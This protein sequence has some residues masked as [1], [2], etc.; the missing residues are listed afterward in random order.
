MSFTFANPKLH[1]LAG[2]EMNYQNWTEFINELKSGELPACYKPLAV[3]EEGF[4]EEIAG[5]AFRGAL[6]RAGGDIT[7]VFL[8]FLD[9]VLMALES[10]T[11]TIYNFIEKYPDIILG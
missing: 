7:K 1:E 5:V 8:D 2:R 6:E 3:A 4:S 9:V 10:D 11:V